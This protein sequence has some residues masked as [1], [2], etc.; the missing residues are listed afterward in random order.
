MPPSRE[1]SL[2]EARTVLRTIRDHIYALQRT[3]AD[4]R[5]VKAELNTLNRQHLNNGVVRERRTQHL[6]RSQ[7]RLGEEA[8][9][10]VVAI[11]TAGAEIKSIDDGLVDFPTRIHGQLAYWCWRAGEDEIEW[12]HLRTTGIVGRRPVSEAS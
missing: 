7:K 11:T 12:W 8:R 2:D 1:F 5:R 9:S 6:H 10:F 4:L 3:Q